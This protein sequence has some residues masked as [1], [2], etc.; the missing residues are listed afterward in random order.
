MNENRRPLPWKARFTVRTFVLTIFTCIGL[1]FGEMVK[2]N[3][4]AAPL[5]GV[6]FCLTML[7]ILIAAVVEMNKP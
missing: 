7:A 2:I 6:L 4:W 5:I 3:D 1:S